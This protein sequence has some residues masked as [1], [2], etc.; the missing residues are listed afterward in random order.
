M[1][2]NARVVCAFHKTMG[3]VV[4]MFNLFIQGVVVAASDAGP[5]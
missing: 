1:E 3:P 5:Q 2:S 4:V